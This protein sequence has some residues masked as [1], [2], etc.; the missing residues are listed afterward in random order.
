M[1]HCKFQI[2]SS[3]AYSVRGGAQT[4]VRVHLCEWP[5]QH[6]ER[7]QSAPLWLL[8]LIG[9]GMAIRPER[10]CV[11][12]PAYTTKDTTHADR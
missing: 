1:E 2:E 10:D 8:K 11:N 6:P 7:F 9:A 3:E 5:D 12:C 4:P